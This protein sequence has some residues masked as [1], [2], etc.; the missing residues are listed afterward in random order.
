MKEG[1]YFTKE[2]IENFCEEKGYNSK[3][4]TKAY[5]FMVSKAIDN[6]KKDPSVIF[7]N[8]RNFGVLYSTLHGCGYEMGRKRDILKNAERF[9]YSEVRLESV[10][11]KMD[12]LSQ[13]KEFIVEEIDTLKESGKKEIAHLRKR[14][15]QRYIKNT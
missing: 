8:I 1:V 3:K 15:N 2:M 10:R 11:R 12:F 4:L 13:R 5:A 6:V 9:D 14:Y 7:Y